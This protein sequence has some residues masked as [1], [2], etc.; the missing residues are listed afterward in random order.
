MEPPRTRVGQHVTRGEARSAAAQPQRRRRLTGT[1]PGPLPR[2][3]VE[4]A[5]LAQRRRRATA[6][7]DLARVRALAADPHV[8]ELAA[9]V[10]EGTQ[11][12]HAVGGRPLRY[13]DWCLV[14][15]GACI[16]VFG[17]ASATARAMADPTIW[18]EVR[19]AAATVIGAEGVATLPVVGPSRDNWS[20]F[21]GHR[22]SEELL[23]HLVS[24]QRDL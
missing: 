21:L 11:R 10:A 13:P 12:D 23:E 22:L 4:V 5:L 2:R 18:S 6:G 3:T 7:T 19:A 15:F 14:L 1:E 9:L 16:R 8:F 17:S 24:A 20:Y